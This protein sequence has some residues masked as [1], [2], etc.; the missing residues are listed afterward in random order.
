MTDERLPDCRPPRRDER[1]TSASSHPELLSG[2]FV[3]RPQS[4]A[5]LAGA[6]RSAISPALRR[7]IAIGAVAAAAVMAHAMFY[8]RS[9]ANVERARSGQPK[10]AATCMQWHQAASAAVARLTESTIDADL[11]QASDAIFRMRR[12][13]R[14]CE[15][16]W[17]ALAC[18]DYY[19]VAR[20]LSGYA[21]TQ[22][23][24]FYACR[25]SAAD[26]NGGMPPIKLPQP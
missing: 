2:D 9:E 14:N 4:H 17:V 3:T 12:A 26:V 23:E 8:Q 10:L 11:R 19:A 5:S 1:I 24:P 13:R 25:R 6:G 18:Q 16:G 20:N 7:L 22:E 15:E 21:N